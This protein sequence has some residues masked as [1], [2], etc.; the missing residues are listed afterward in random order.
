MRTRRPVAFAAALVLAASAFACGKDRHGSPGPGGSTVTGNVANAATASVM[1][2]RST[3]L[4]WLGEQIF[5]FARPAYAQARDTTLGGITVIVRGG[6]RELS[7]LTDSNGN[8]SIADAPTGEITIIFRRGSCEGSLPVGGVISSSTLTLVDASFIC[9]PGSDVG[10]VSLTDLDERFLGVMRDDPSDPNSI[11]LC[12][13]VG[14][15]DVERFVAASNDIEDSNGNQTSFSSLDRHDRLQIDGFRSDAG[16]NF[17]FDTQRIQVQQH[18]V[19]DDCA[20]V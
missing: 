13:R 10:D 7:D 3:W 6:G 14:N 18:D 12:T 4:A 20:G 9:S 17:T 5:G 16:D 11:R 19:T 15:D 8:F 1:P 2:S